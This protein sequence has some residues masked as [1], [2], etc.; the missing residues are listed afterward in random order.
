MKEKTPLIAK[1]KKFSQNSDFNRHEGNK[2]FE[3]K[4][5]DKKFSQNNNFNRYVVSVHE[6]N[7]PFIC[8]LCEKRFRWINVFLHFM[9]EKCKNLI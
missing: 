1:W 5:C 4:I 9:K 3:C 6:G 8:K 7:M 2:P